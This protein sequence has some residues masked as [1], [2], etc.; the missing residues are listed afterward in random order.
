MILKLFTSLIFMLHFMCGVTLS[1]ETELVDLGRW[2]DVELEK[3][4]IS[5]NQIDNPGDRIVALSSHFV[6]TPYAANTLIGGPQ[7]TEQLVINLTGFDCF[8][9]LDVVEALRRTSDAEDFPVQ[10]KKVRYREGTV[11]YE[12]RRHF[13]SD[14]V[15]GSAAVIHDVT[16][17]V[18][19]GRAQNM[20]KQL[21]RKSDGTLWLPEIPVTPREIIF[22]PSGKIDTKVLSRLQSGD[23]VGIFSTHAGL[24]VTHTGLIV[25]SKDNIMLRHASSRSSVKRVVDEDL[26]DYLQ[27]KPGLVVYRANP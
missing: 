20:S 4:I 26:L 7:E 25:K 23:Y 3:I 2:N 8:T 13:F 15:T 6:D 11:V 14:W 21:N 19:Q 18:G 1:A 24:D 27:G 5:V 16:A 10:L 17:E 12:K 9:F 22:I